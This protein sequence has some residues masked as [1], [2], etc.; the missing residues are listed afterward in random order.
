MISKQTSILSSKILSK[1]DHIRHEEDLQREYNQKFMTDRK[2]NLSTQKSQK[3]L[4]S[5]KITR[6]DQQNHPLSTLVPQKLF[7]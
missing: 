4:S 6:K 2:K 5:S 1:I 3:S 7:F